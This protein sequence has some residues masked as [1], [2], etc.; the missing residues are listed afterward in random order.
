MKIATPDAIAYSPRAAALALGISREHIRLAIKLGDLP[1]YKL[2][3][4][5][6]LVL[7]DDLIEW[8]RRQTIL[9]GLSVLPSGC[10]A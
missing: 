9:P 3:K 5:R 8:I 4:C 2:G 6:T 10:H 1:A 7:R